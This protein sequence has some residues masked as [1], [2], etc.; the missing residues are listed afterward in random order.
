VARRP[1]QKVRI[2]GRQRAKRAE[3][4]AQGKPNFHHLGGHRL[5]RPGHHHDQLDGLYGIFYVIYKLKSF[6]PLSEHFNPNE[7]AGWPKKNRFPFVCQSGC[8]LLK[9]CGRILIL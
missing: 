6:N 5:R 1:G 4:T 9:L 2:D 3:K 8:V 7:I